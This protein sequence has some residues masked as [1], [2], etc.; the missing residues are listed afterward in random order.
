M[1]PASCTLRPWLIL[2]LVA[3]LVAGCSGPKLVPVTGK[4]TLNGQPLK[5]V[6][7]DFHP[8]PDQGTTGPSSTGTTDD[9]GNFTLV[10]EER[11]GAA[12]AVVGHHRVILSDLDIYGNVFVGRGDYR[13]EGPKGP[14]E[15]PKNPRFGAVYSDLA[16]T[17]FKQE[18]TAGMGAVTFEVKK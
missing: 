11:G 3:V 5:N 1:P 18:V 9:S 10:C 8:D 13:T 2:P 14:K 15:T 6:R 7:V 12:G 16:K 4:V 17:P